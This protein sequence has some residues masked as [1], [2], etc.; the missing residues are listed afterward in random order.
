MPTTPLQ[1][2]LRLLGAGVT[3]D[4]PSSWCMQLLVFP[5]TFAGGA[6]GSEFGAFGSAPWSH[7]TVSASREMPLPLA[8]CSTPIPRGGGACGTVTLVPAVG[9]PICFSA[10]RD[11]AL[12]VGCGCAISSLSS[13]IR[14]IFPC[15]QLGRLCGCPG[16]SRQGRVKSRFKQD[17]G[18]HATVGFPAECFE[19]GGGLRGRL[20]VF[21]GRFGAPVFVPHLSVCGFLLCRTRPCAVARASGIADLMPLAVRVTQSTFAAP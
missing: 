4:V 14:R 2:G 10:A 6:L 3:H 16:C 20:A 5:A 21:A 18:R 8:G 13:K 9:P 11:V 15:W 17:L 12:R 19:H 1:S 7:R